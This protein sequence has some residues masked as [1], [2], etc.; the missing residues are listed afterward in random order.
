MAIQEAPKSPGAKPKFF[1]GYT[2]VVASFFVMALTWGT[3]HAFGVFFNPV[4]TEFGWTRAMT[5]GAFSLSLL[6]SG[7]SAILWEG[8]PI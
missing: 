4:L 7:F 3:F 1:Y 6:V 5:S 8:S 2:V